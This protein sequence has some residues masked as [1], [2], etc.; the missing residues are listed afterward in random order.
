MEDLSC[1]FHLRPH[2]LSH[3]T[4]IIWL[5]PPPTANS[6]LFFP[7]S[8]PFF[9]KDPC[10]SLLQGPRARREQKPSFSFSPKEA[11]SSSVG[12]ACLPGKEE[13]EEVRPREVSPWSGGAGRLLNVD[14]THPTTHIFKG[15]RGGD[16]EEELFSLETKEERLGRE[17][18]KLVEEEEEED[19]GGVHGHEKR[20]KG[21]KEEGE[22]C[23]QEGVT[24]NKES[25]RGKIVVSGA[26]K[27]ETET[28]EKK[29][30]RKRREEEVEKKG[31]EDKEEE[32]DRKD[33]GEE[34]FAIRE[35]MKLVESYFKCVQ[36][37]LP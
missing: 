25:E 21:Q 32:E 5:S 1:L 36:G 16:R 31:V 6:I 29:K 23:R 10:Q 12:E 3:I 24:G 33:E 18:E 35:D 14:V 11:A 34:L 17:N 28:E 15:E 19:L 30:K 22:V 26:E 7:S 2:S 4:D 27:K 9:L 20:L 37:E 13:K 8:S